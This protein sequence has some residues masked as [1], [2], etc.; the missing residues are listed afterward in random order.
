MT[1]T[2]SHRVV[3]AR[4]DART[5]VRR[6]SVFFGSM[7]ALLASVVFAGFAP[8]FYMRSQLGTLPPLAPLFILHGA[9]FSAWMLFILMQV[10][11]VTASALRWH[12]RLGRAGAV[13]AVLMTATGIAAQIEHTRA[14]VMDGTYGKNTLIEDLGLSLSFLD[15]GVFMAFVAVGIWFR[16]HAEQHKRLMLLATLAVVGPAVVRLPGITA[17][18]PP[19]VVMSPVVFVIPLVVY[20]FL[21]QRRASSVSLWGVA[22][23][24]GYHILAM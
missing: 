24:A 12:A 10:G 8:T 13:L 9:L 1:D 6:D 23:M 2:P 22:V 17:L 4:H 19:M 21:T 15:V 16:Q 11:L 3:L 7:A 14:V 20:D 5:R 18:P